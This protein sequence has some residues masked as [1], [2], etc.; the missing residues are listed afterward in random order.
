M[1]S[2]AMR[3]VR[4][5]TAPLYPLGLP[6]VFLPAAHLVARRLRRRRLG[7]ASAIVAS[8]WLGWLAHRAIKLRYA[9][10]RPSRRGIARRTDSYPSGHTTGVTAV[11]VTIARVLE[12]D[13]VLSRREARLLA[14]GASAI[15]GAYRVVDDE[16]WT[17]DV[18]GGWLF[19]IAIS[20]A[21]TALATGSAAGSQRLKRELFPGVLSTVISPPII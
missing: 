12:R 2:D 17:T 10:V 13:G 1:Q 14:I 6:G 11:A 4:S 21:C 9:R 3:R 16:H 15:M 19:G 8:A 7:G 5:L 20:Y 18:I